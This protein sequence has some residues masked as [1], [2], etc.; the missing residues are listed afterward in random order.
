[1]EQSAQ[2]QPSTP[3]FG[4]RLSQG[5]LHVDQG[6][7]GTTAT[8]TQHT[9]SQVTETSTVD[10]GTRIISSRIPDPNDNDQAIH[11]LLDRWDVAALI[12]NKM[13]GTGIF[14]GPPMVLLYTQSKV[15][16]IFLW[17]LGLVYTYLW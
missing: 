9:E 17:I 15:E 11:P 4:H 5:L 12:I 1:M 2:N 14:T 7:S 10:A 16:A 3:Q 13:V 6:G 8:E